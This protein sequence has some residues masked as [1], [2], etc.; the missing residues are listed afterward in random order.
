[1]TAP[2]ALVSTRLVGRDAT[3]GAIDGF[4][5]RLENGARELA[6]VTGPVG[7]GRSAVLDWAVTR[8]RAAGL[9][10]GVARC[11]PRESRIP[12]GTVTQLMATLCPPSRF[13]ALAGALGRGTR[14]TAAVAHTCDALLTESAG[15]P[16][17]LA[18]DDVHL[19]DPDS[20]RWLVELGRR[21][22]G[23]PVLALGTSPV[24]DRQVLAAAGV[25]ARAGTCP[26]HTLRLD[27]LTGD[28]AHTLLATR[29]GRPVPKAVLAATA[30]AGGAPAVLRAVADRIAE[31]AGPLDTDALPHLVA[32]ARAAWSARAL[33]TA[34]GL[35]DNAVGLLRVVAAVGHLLD[36]GQMA[37]IAGLDAT[38][39]DDAVAALRACGLLADAD[40]P[41]LAHAWF[42]DDVLA[43]LTRA[44]RDTLHLRATAL[45]GGSGARIGTVAD[46]LG[47][48]TGLVRPWT[49]SDSGPA[50]RPRPADVTTAALRHALREPVTDTERARLLLRLAAVEAVTAP[51]ASDGRLRQVMLRHATPETWPAVLHA[52]DL[53]LSR[54][55]AETTR[56][57][58]A[59]V[60]QRALT[61]IPDA[62]LRPLRALGRLAGDEKGGPPLVAPPPVHTDHPGHPAQAAV[63]A[64]TLAARADDRVRVLD[65]ARTT[66]AEPAAV[67]LMC[68]IAAARAL[69]C[70][71]DVTGGLDRLDAV[72]TDARHTGARAAA[73]QALLTRAEV[74]VRLGRPEDGLRDLATATRELPPASWHTLLR[75]RLTAAEILALIRCGRVDEARRVAERARTRP[76]GHSVTS[77]FLLYARAELALIDGDATRALLLLEECGR[78]L[79]SKRWRNPMLIAWRG[80]AAVAHHQLGAPATAAELLTEEHRVVERW[81]TASAFTAV[82]TRT[83][84][85]LARYGVDLPGAPHRDE[86][87]DTPAEAGGE[88]LSAAE[89]AVTDL[90]VQGLGNREIAGRLGL[91]TRTVEL[92]LTK[93]YRRL[94]VKGRPALVTRLL[95]GQEDG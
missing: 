77:G 1:M 91:S 86:P 82:R 28:E 73:A 36:F 63:L 16:V 85:T 8:A 68:R 50:T 51:Q 12:Y 90:V 45:Q 55:D 52:A 4:V 88:A 75:P 76:E 81:G 7:A 56:W 49:A 65:L 35:S 46:M 14:P 3:L 38:P 31:L 87:A 47:A 11:S 2:P 84:D 61:V 70:A 26:V 24:P 44:E 32:T 62:Q 64:W 48:V 57:V 71:G 92:R 19:A 15:R 39:F 79:R 33:A 6:V 93:L 78:L 17:L 80:T 30:V 22:H 83:H 40:T 72:V 53:L 43:G 67:P 66:L 20:L 27:P 29:A 9:A 13:G 58:I 69:L 21:S 37:A 10:V 42:A 94:G 23:G 54:G 74:A 59:D 5:T 25:P 34:R 41:R 89:R 18:V 95:A 60:H